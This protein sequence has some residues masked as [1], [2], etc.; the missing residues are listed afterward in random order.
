VWTGPCF[1]NGEINVRGDHA[2]VAWIV[3]TGSWEGVALDGLAVVAALDAEGTLHTNAE[4]PVKSVVFVDEKADAGQSRALVALA[5][6]LAPKHLANIVK[7]ERRSISYSRDGFES[8]LTAGSDVTLKTTSLGH[9]DKVCCN[10]E[11]AY[12]PVG[13]SAR[14]APAKTLENAY[15]GSA[16]GGARWSDPDKRSALIGTFAR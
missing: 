3:R 7:V 2:V 13:G 12:P 10:E 16:L 9:C 15:Q 5:R 4:G 1:A 6:S 8:S 14:V 11:M